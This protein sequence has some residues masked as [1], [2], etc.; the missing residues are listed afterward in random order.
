V[1]V[2]GVGVRAVT[3]E[4]RYRGLTEEVAMGLFSRLRRSGR[5]ADGRPRA[6]RRGGS[7]ASGTDR[8]YL[9]QWA[10]ARRGVEGFVEPR[11]SLNPPSILLVAHDGEW[12][13]R[14]VPSERVA[15]DWAR[16]L[17]LPCYD[18]SLVGYPRRMNE[19]KPMADG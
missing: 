13:R 18:A 9:E 11:T 4:C 12:T 6:G 14:A 16:G 15:F 8:A 7:Q 10:A 3:L 1:F 5:G 19:W 2:P 17:G